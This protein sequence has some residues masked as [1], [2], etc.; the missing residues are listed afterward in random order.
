MPRSVCT[1]QGVGSLSIEC[2]PSDG[3][4]YTFPSGFLVEKIYRNTTG[5][6]GPLTTVIGQVSGVC[7]P[8][9]GSAIL[10]DCNNKTITNCVG[11]TNCSSN[12]CTVSP[13]ILGCF[14]TQSSF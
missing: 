1:Q 14:S 3:S 12:Q 8:Q 4:N 9:S 10:Y 6:S 11:T 2:S 13:L 5:C 7:V